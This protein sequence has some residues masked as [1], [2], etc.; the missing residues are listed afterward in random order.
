VSQRPLRIALF[1][2]NYNYLREGANQALNKLVAYL[3]RQG[4]AVRAYSPV[5]DT[6]AFE[7]EGTL[8]PV[9]SI[10]LPIRTE[11]RLALGMPRFIRRD[12]ERF[13]PDLVHLSTPD[14]LNTRAETFAIR[15]NI[16]IVASLH[17]R[18]ET[19]PEH[20]P[21]LAWLAPLAV[22][23]QRRFYRRA[24]CVLAP[25][26]PLV[27]EMKAL[28]GD[29]HVALW[30]RGID[31]TLFSPSQRDSG[32]RRAQGWRDDDIVLLF[33]GR[34]VLEK[35]VDTF[36]ETVRLLRKSRPNIRALIVGAGPAEPRMRGLDGA[37]FTG[38]LDGEELAR[39]VASADLMLHPSRSE[40]FGNVILEAMASG[41]PLVCADA[42]NA[43]SLIDPRRTGLLVPSSD[44]VDYAAAAER[45]IAAPDERRRIAHAALEASGAYS[46]DDVSHAVEAAY[47]ET[48]AR[49][50]RRIA[51]SIR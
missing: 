10:P 12:V 33:F 30:S 18:F 38:H 46:W 25:T 20:Y 13:A 27:E 16:P 2:G 39:A 47:F 3:E 49:Y 45:L 6:P 44:P 37:V 17:T 35:G 23:Q 21:G 28:R 43:R 40:A 19:Y 5:T 42:P 41:V 24:D 11:F 4:H 48:L 50:R 26:E 22:A 15:R 8:V 31:A 14:I 36:V 1:S 32:W 34:L 7:P 51:G 29:D 9:P